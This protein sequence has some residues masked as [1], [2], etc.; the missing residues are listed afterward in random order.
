[1]RGHY[2]QKKIVQTFIKQEAIISKEKKIEVK[3]GHYLK[4]KNKNS[5]N[6]YLQNEMA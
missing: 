5:A 6:I 2:F 3:K 4:K 1:M